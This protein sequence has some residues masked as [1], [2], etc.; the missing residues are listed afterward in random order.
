MFALRIVLVALIAFGLI[1]LIGGRLL[2]ESLTHGGL[3]PVCNGEGGPCEN[4][5]GLGVIV[6]DSHKNQS[7]TFQSKD[8]SRNPRKDS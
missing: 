7:L 3:C 8:S 6:P 1:W 2:K 4:C 5:N